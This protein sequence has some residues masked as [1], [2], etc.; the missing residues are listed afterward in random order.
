MPEFVRRVT[1]NAKDVDERVLLKPEWL[2]TNGLGGYASGTV[3][4]PVTRRYH[5]L[6]VAALPTPL[7][8]TVLLSHL[9]ERVRLPDRTIVVLGAEDHAGALELAGARNLIE[10]RLEDGLPVWRYDLGGIELEKR[11]LMPHGQNT[12]YVR[13]ALPGNHGLLRLTLRP[14]TPFRSHHAPLNE[15]LPGRLVMTATEGRYEN[16]PAMPHTTR[17]RCGPG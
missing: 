8:R 11:V 14:S 7:G 17:A 2:V 10:F 4:G 3:A 16:A 5:G 13:Y 1:W 15:P 9:W 12:V 6:L